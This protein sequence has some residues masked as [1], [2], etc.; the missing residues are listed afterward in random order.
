[1][2][3][4]ERVQRDRLRDAYATILS[5]LQASDAKDL[6]DD[7]RKLLR[8]QL[9]QERDAAESAQ[10]QLAD[11]R[12]EIDGKFPEFVA[13]VSPVNPSLD[14]IQ[15]TLQRDEA[16]IG[17][18]PTREGTFVWAVNASGK[19]ALAVSR[20]TESDV[21]RRVDAM[22]G[23]LDVGER[24]PNL[25]AMDFAAALEL[26]NELIRPLRPALEG[27]AVV[28]ISAAGP[29][30]ALPLATLVTG[31]SKE[32]KT[33][34][35]LVRDFA[36]AQTPGAAAFVSLRTQEVAALP[37]KPLLGF[38]DPLFRVAAAAATAP[39]PIA[40]ATA[41]ATRAAPARR[42][43]SFARQCAAGGDLFAGSRFSLRRHTAVARDPRRIGRARANGGSRSQGGPRARRRGDAQGGARHAARR[44]Q[45]RR[46][47]DARPAAGEI[48]GLSKPA[49]A[50]A[51]TDDPNDSP[52]L[53]LDDVL[54]L[55]LRAQWVVLSACNTAGGERD[56]AAMSGLVRGFFYAGTRSVLAT[57]WAVESEASRQ[58][59]GQIFA[60]QAKDARGNRAASLEACA[61]CDDRR[62][63][64][65]AAATRTRS[66]GHRTRC[67]ATRRAEGAMLSA[68]RS[69][70]LGLCGPFGPPGGP[71]YRRLS[72]ACGRS[73]VAIADDSHRRRAGAR[74]SSR[75]RRAFRRRAIAA[76]ARHACRHRESPRSGRHCRRRIRRPGAGGWLHAAARYVEHARA[77]AAREQQRTLRSGARFQAG[78]QPVPLDQGDLGAVG[79]AGVLAAGVRS[80]RERAAGSA[81]LRDRGRRLVEPHRRRAVRV[82][83][84]ARPRARSV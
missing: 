56:G 79:A 59:V 43:I 38:G 82:R 54:S 32:L 6:T 45:D 22:R 49:L 11:I 64:S 31:P 4:R 77:R 10:K 73:A 61:A 63:R 68:R 28:N 84:E 26:Y 34:A 47:R 66:T 14:T 69:F 48:P 25:P 52:L 65:A 42:G 51:A 13:L 35:W 15:K 7:K 19:R 62:V 71:R 24:L 21:A 30:A 2:L 9:R 27:A 3:A 58:L 75:P 20:W 37:A 44:P 83:G 50:M 57:H 53:T 70:A 40:A 55:K 78:R 23:A 60:E 17:L 29:L 80:L 76:G 67:S 41:G 1:V 8:D 46:V 72:S 36:I 33:A 74:R 39:A 12:R 18:Y 16:F 81:Q 5:T